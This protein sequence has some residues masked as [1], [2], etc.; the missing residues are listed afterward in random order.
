MVLKVVPSRPFASAWSTSR[1]TMVGA[2]NIERRP[3]AWPSANSSAGSKPPEAGTTWRAPA[4]M[5]GMA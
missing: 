2:A 3:I 5:C 1:L 4:I